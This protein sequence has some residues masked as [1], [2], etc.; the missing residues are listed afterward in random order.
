MRGLFR[1][2]LCLMLQRSRALLVMVGVGVIMGFSTD[3]P[4]VVG[5]LTMIGAILAVGTISYDEFDNGYPFLMTLP[6]TRKDYVLEKYLFCLVTCL[7]SWVAALVIYGVCGLARGEGFSPEGLAEG[8]AF[9]P[10]AALLL[11]IMLPVQL[12][13]GAEKSRVVL[14]MVC[15]GA[16]GAGYLIMK[17][18]PGG[19]GIAE[20]LSRISD[21]AIGV[22]FLVISLAALALSIR[23]S[24]GIMEKKEL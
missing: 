5:Y 23:I 19:D 20:G 2:D 3:G 17:L 22:G 4:F 8:V 14:I 9:L 16:F 1:K 10:V 12:K 18:L 24:I 11:A 13:Y 6:V 15:G 21:G 7:V